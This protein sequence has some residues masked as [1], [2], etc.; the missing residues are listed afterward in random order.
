MSRALLWPF[1][2]CYALFLRWTI[3]DAR[4]YLA[5]CARDGLTDSLSLREFR[6]EI[7]RDMVRLADVQARMQP[8]RRTA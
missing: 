6:A 3:W 5:A 7:D 8:I 1:L 4:M 2:A